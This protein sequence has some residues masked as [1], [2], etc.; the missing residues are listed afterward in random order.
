MKRNYREMDLVKNALE[1]TKFKQSR[2][3][4]GQKQN[5]KRAKIN[6]ANQTVKQGKTKN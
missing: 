6:K 4:F 3:L 5:T 1:C 2:T